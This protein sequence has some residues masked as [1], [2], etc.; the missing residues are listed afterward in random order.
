MISDENQRSPVGQLR[1]ALGNVSVPELVR[2]LE[3]ATRKKALHQ[4]NRRR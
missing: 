1:K 4:R 2:D 3:E